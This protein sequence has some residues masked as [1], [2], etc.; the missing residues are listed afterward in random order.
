MN[1]F[2]ICCIVVPLFFGTWSSTSH[3]GTINVDGSEFGR[4]VRVV[5]A[6]ASIS[7]V[8]QDLSEKFGF[9]V[10]GLEHADAKSAITGKLEGSLE[11]VLKRVLRNQNFIVVHAHGKAGGITRVRLLSTNTGATQVPPT[12]DPALLGA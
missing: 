9:S 8:L 3:A 4:T 11:S 6:D 10:E 5:A 1:M 2:S 7:S 12:V